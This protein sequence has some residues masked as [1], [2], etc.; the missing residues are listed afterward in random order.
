MPGSATVTID[1]TSWCVSI[2]STPAEWAQ[3][4]GGLASLPAGW[5]ML[6]DLGY[7]RQ[8]TV[9]TRP[10]LFDLDILFL[11][12]QCLVTDVRRNA[13]LGQE[14]TRT[15]R[16]FLEVN[17]GEAVNIQAGDAAQVAPPQID[18]QVPITETLLAML[19]VFAII[20][21]GLSTILKYQPG[22]GQ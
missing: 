7:S 6:F 8:V 11:D 9:T 16:Y 13:T 14:I 22:F 18:D 12:E 10:M 19:M 1:T 15:C 2:A 20:T 4:L 21:T 5:G 17:A 3:G